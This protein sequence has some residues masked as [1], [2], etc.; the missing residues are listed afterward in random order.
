MHSLVILFFVPLLPYRPL[1]AGKTADI[2]LGAVYVS[3]AQNDKVLES[4]LHISLSLEISEKT[5]E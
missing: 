3:L 2:R 1:A 5:E 4:T